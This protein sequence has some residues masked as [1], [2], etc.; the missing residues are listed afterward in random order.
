VE[1]V[2]KDNK[3]LCVEALIK[4]PK[5]GLARDPTV[6][7]PEIAA[8]VLAFPVC[9]LLTW[10][11]TRFLRKRGMVVPDAHKEGKPLVPRPGGPAILAAIT[12]S[13]G[14]IYFVSGDIRAAA[15]VLV[16][17]IAGAV[18]LV[19]DLR[20]LNGPLKV[21]LLF[22]AAVPIIVLEAYAPRIS[23]PFGASLTITIVYPFLVL[24][25]I[26][27]TANTFNMIDVYN[28]LLTG[29]AA[30]AAVPLLIAFI[31]VGDW[32]MFSV[33]VAYLLLLA[34]FYPFHMN[35]SKVFPGDSGSLALGAAY[36]AIV[37]SGSMDLVG[38]VALIPA[39]LNSFFVLSSVRSFM[40]HRNMKKRPVRLRDDYLLEASKDKDSPMTLSRMVLAGGPLSE[41]D[42]VSAIFVIE[43]V[44]VCLSLVTFIMLRWTP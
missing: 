6:L 36:G 4:V 19:D 1:S 7:W 20:T 23:L 28:G 31:V 34:G 37:I 11:L 26:P 15:F 14:L 42:V 22:L 38:V 24:L 10:Y 39:I 5:A 30:L 33:T 13:G 18:G 43:L 25:A 16:A 27:I 32:V 12:V 41:Q 29:F 2:F 40:E 17:L 21:V 3:L 8:S 44:A 35:P 9:Y